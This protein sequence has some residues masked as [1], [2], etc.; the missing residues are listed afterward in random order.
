MPLID[1]ISS[2]K[3]ILSTGLE[4]QLNY[5]YYINAPWEKMAVC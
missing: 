3:A 5:V 1:F 4:I 2:A